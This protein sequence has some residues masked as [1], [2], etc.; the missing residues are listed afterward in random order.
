MSNKN[1]GKKPENFVQKLGTIM[2]LYL[3]YILT[4]AF[5]QIIYEIKEVVKVEI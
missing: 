1:L 4:L 5:C 3:V 2:K